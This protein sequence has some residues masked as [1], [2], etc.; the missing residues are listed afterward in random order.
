MKVAVIHEWLLV[1][2][3]AEKVLA[4]IL[5]LFPDADLFCLVDF[6]P[7]EKRGFIGNRITKTSFIQKLP[8]AENKY[9]LY[10]P[11]MP[12]AV[13]QFDLGSYDL[14]ISCNY[15]VAKGVITG[16][17]QLHIS[18]IHSPMRY[19]WD[20]QFQYL[21]QTNLEKGLKSWATRWLLHKM[22]IWD[23]RTA[24][25]VDY[26]I[27]NSNFIAR[28]IKKVY[29]RTSTTIYPPVDTEY[30]TPAAGED[31]SIKKDFYLTVSRMVPYKYMDVIVKAFAD[32]PERKLVVIGDG[33][34]RDRLRKLAGTN[35]EILGHVNREKVRDYMRRAKA[36]IFAA[37]EDFGIVPLEAQ[38]CGT[39]VIAYGKGG[40]KETIV[41]LSE[42][43]G[44]SSATGIFFSKQ[45]SE[46]LAKVV[47]EFA[48][49]GN[50]ITASDCRE[51]AL[52]F[53]RSHFRESFKVFVETHYREFRQK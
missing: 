2:A 46:N 25:G 30:F 32:M 41:G 3:G 6:L 35:I 9:R 16:P 18:Y 37:E 19:A 36:F 10:L 44:T 23:N 12:L 48:E 11:L 34:E 31:S 8:F 42:E 52:R 51:N 14:V 1:E 43:S 33:P 4:E 49:K 40:A 20:L 13:E 27:S 5:D 21:K 50:K 38:A 24:H 28:R 26:Y 7:P 17:N 15:A 47:S 53:S 45:T 22:R 39:P 29:G